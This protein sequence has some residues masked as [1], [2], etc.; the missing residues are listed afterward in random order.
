MIR[1]ALTDRRDVTCV[2][3]D[4]VD[5]ALDA[6]RAAVVA[7]HGLIACG[8][9]GTFAVAATAAA[10]TNSPVAVIANGTGNDMAR[11]LG[12]RARG[13][14]PALS[15]LDR[16]W[17]GRIDM[18]RVIDAAGD[19]TMMPSVVSIGLDAAANARAETMRWLHGS[20]RYP[21]SALRVLRNFEPFSV[22]ITLDDNA[23]ELRRAWMVSI[24]NTPTYAGGMRIAP[25]ALMR[26]GALDVVTVGPISRP[27][28]LRNI[29]KVYRGTHTNHPAVTI[30]TAQRVRVR[31]F[32]AT[33]LEGWASGERIGQLPFEISCI[34]NALRVLVPPDHPLAEAP[35]NPRSGEA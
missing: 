10:E 20:V 30:R 17:T 33:G 11:A 28:L 8:G 13:P 24:A 14:A 19:V 16:G 4:S 23:P 12:V 3:T 18:A 25:N 26:D 21:M 1:D 31:S 29:P 22:E 32:E 7:G 9:D 15:L 6:A 35:L 34:P 5:A 27:E 2:E